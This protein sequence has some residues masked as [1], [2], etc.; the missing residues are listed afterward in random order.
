MRANLDC[1]H[2]YGRLTVMALL[3]GGRGRMRCVCGA[4][5]E[6]DLYDVRSGHTTSCGCARRE[7]ASRN[8]RKAIR[9]AIAARTKHGEARR[10][11]CS[12]TYRAWV[13]MHNRCS[14]HA[15]EKHNRDY[16]QRGIRVCKRWNSY[17]AFLADMGK[18]PD[19]LT[20]DRIN[21]D[22]NYEP[23]NCRWATQSQQ[24]KNRRPRAH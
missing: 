20:L 7:A 10:G 4:V 18:R 9:A 3:G 23:G 2:V 5:V 17:E 21:N 6:R 11:R 24:A 15:S 16:F 1:G 22:G 14:G 13:A 12:T 19:N 8:G